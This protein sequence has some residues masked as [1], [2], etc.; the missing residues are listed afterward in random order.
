MVA[1]T[2]NSSKRKEGKMQSKLRIVI[3]VAL[4]VIMTCSSFARS[5]YGYVFTPAWGERVR[6]ELY[7]HTGRCIQVTTSYSHPFSGLGTRYHFD[8]VRYGRHFVKVTRRNGAWRETNWF[9][10]GF[11]FWTDTRVVDIR[12]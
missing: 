5:I 3:F 6:V 1:T 2:S 9:L 11:G 4:M 7:D 12:L 10:T 8:N